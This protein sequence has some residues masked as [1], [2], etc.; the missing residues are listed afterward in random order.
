MYTTP[1]L[2]CT[3]RGLPLTVVRLTDEF[4]HDWVEHNYPGRDGA[5]VESMGRKAARFSGEAVFNGPTW[6]IQA[7]GFVAMVENASLTGTG[8]FVHPFW[9]TFTGTMLSARITHEDRKHDHARVEFTFLEAEAAPFA[10]AVAST[11]A[12]AAAAASAASAAV[13]AA[14]AA[15]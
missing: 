6:H 13:A 4:G 5:E 11:L 14:L 15:L 1:P 7:L 8:D 9:E 2:S 12:S 10:F 3:W